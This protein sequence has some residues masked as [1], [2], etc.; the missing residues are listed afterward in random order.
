MK[1]FHANKQLLMII[2]NQR[3]MSPPD[4]FSILGAILFVAF[5]LL[6]VI[7][8][9]G[10]GA[11]SETRAD[12]ARTYCSNV[13]F[14]HPVQTPTG[15]QQP[16]PKE[17]QKKRRYCQGGFLAALENKAPKPKQQSPYGPC[18]SRLYKNNNAAAA[19]CHSA[20]VYAFNNRA[21][22]RK[23]PKQLTEAEKEEVALQKEARNQCNDM[24]IPAGS[25]QAALLAACVKGY[26]GAKKNKTKANTCN[27]YPGIN[28]EYCQKG[29]D[30][31]KEDDD[32]D[33]EEEECGA[34]ADFSLAWIMC[35]IIESAQSTSEKFYDDILEPLLKKVPIN[36][37]NP[38]APGY[39]SYTAWQSFRVLANLILVGAMLLLVYG[40]VRNGGGR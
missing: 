9:A 3:L 28:R 11:A 21:Q 39:A 17:V 19:V 30:L 23:L 8:S 12:R 40:M 27:S 24:G 37:N 6:Q 32:A 26:T 18:Y 1:V 31:A 16:D 29:F 7:V 33:A 15:L 38:S 20:Y 34:R 13:S 10:V 22:L 5:I 35:P 25:N 4:S 2:K 36:V 14:N